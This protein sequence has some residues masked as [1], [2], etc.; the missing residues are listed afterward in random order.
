MS[1]KPHLIP[2]W[3]SIMRGKAKGNRPYLECFFVEIRKKHFF[4]NFYFGITELEVPGTWKLG[5]WSSRNLGTWE[6]GNLGT[7][8]RVSLK[9][10]AYGERWCLHRSALKHFWSCWTIDYHPWPCKDNNKIFYWSVKRSIKNNCD[11]LPNSVG[12]LYVGN[13]IMSFLWS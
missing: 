1:R 8:L 4:V 5:T 2:A 3:Q 6:L 12:L 10:E 11:F 9:L 13:L 7:C